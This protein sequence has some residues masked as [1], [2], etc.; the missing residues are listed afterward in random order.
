MRT[1]HVHI[2]AHKTG[3]TALQALMRGQGVAFAEAGIAI[4]RTGVPEGL[5]GHHNIAWEVV[6]N[7]RFSPDSGTLSELL[8]EIEGA[9]Q[10]LISA[11]GFSHLVR[12]PDRLA[13]FREDLAERGWAPRY[14][15]FHRR[16]ADYFAAMHKEMRRHGGGRP[17]L[18]LCRPDVEALVVVAVGRRRRRRRTGRQGLGPTD[19]QK[20]GEIFHVDL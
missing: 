14:I 16:P 5:Y 19:G 20:I 6:G 2:G 17:F 11:E 12:H 10:A 9:D 4:P 15:W 13:R 3:T 1:L 8:D 18:L 7:P